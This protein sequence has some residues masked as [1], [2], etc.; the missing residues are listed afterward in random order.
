MFGSVNKREQI[1]IKRKCGQLKKSAMY[2]F[3]DEVNCILNSQADI[4]SYF[5]RT[6]SNQ[7]SKARADESSLDELQDTQND[8]QH[9]QIVIYNE[10]SC[11]NNQ[12]EQKYNERMSKI[13]SMLKEDVYFV[14]K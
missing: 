14:P 9:T 7:L 4:P 1:M 13:Q 3:Y 5:K 10:D 12:A 6:T 11:K 2:F 8:A